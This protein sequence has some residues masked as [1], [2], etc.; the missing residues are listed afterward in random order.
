MKAQTG[1]WIGQGWELVKADLGMMMLVALVMTAL[2]SVVPLIM[3]GPLTVGFHIYIIKKMTGKVAEIGDLFK[4]FN[5]FLPA[6]VA[7]IL[8]GL[9]VSLGTMLCIIPGLVVAA[10]L[11]FTYLLIL[12]KRLDF[13][14]AMQAS[15]EIVKRDYFGYTMFILAIAGINILGFLCCIV[16]LLVTIP[17]SIA[18]TT[19]AYREL[20]GFEQATLDSL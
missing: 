10:A 2:N 17:I 14:P 4:G 20:V 3:Q 13:W 16:G 11:H 12:D 7:S 19:F 15:H 6:L 8:I 1:R 18:A 9:F 5:F